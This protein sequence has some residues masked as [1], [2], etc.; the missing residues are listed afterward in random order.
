MKAIIEVPFYKRLGTNLLSLILIGF[1]F[2][3]GQHILIPL[4]F[5]ILLAI[6]LLPVTQFLQRMRFNRI[7]SILFAL[8]GAMLIIASIVYFLTSQIANFLNDMPTIENRLGMLFLDVKQ[9]VS[10][11]FNISIVDQDNYVTETMRSIQNSG[12]GGIVGKTFF[13][14]TGAISYVFFLPIYTFLILYYQDHFKQFLIDVFKNSQEEKV[15]EVLRESLS[16]SQLYL[17]GLLTELII[18][19]ALNATGFFVLG[20]K[21]ALFMGLLAALLNLIPYI[22]MVIANAFCMLITVISCDHMG[23]VLLVAV[24]LVVVHFIDNSFIMPLVVGS[25]VRINALAIIVG[26]LIGGALFGIFGMFLA[27]PGLAVLKVMF[28][29]VDGLQPYGML[30]GDYKGKTPKPSQPVQV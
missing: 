13:T 30:L 18:V 12:A 11:N 14:L 21:Y 19:F 16:I 6:L 28:D 5:S 9:W 24:V 4:L 7:L 27:I 15:R 23:Q 26:V 22:G 8:V 10:N 17:T 29:R 25:K 2:Y 20:I 1:I 3:I